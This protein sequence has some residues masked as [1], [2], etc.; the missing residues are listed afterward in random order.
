VSNAGR[1]QHLQK[2]LPNPCGGWH[3][4]GFCIG[5]TEIINFW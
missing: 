4:V 1:A 2:K 5:R 3:E